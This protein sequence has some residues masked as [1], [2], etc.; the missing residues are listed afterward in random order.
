MYLPTVSVRRHSCQRA[1]PPNQA[2]KSL[3][4]LARAVIKFNGKSGDTVVDAEEDALSYPLETPRRRQPKTPPRSAYDLDITAILPQ[5]FCM[6]QPWAHQTN[7]DSRKNNIDEVVA[8]PRQVRE[9][10]PHFQ[11]IRNQYDYWKL[12]YQVLDSLVAT[13][14]T[15]APTPHSRSCSVSA[16]RFNSGCLCTHRA[17]RAPLQNGISRTR[18]SRRSYSMHANVRP[19]P[20]RSCS[21][22]VSARRQS[23]SLSTFPSSFRVHG[24]LGAFSKIVA[25]TSRGGGR[26]SEA[27][28][29]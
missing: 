25:S 29:A 5:L 12:K 20:R 15:S 14:P 3:F 7:K 6:G 9:P 19:I 28:F 22:T 17:L 1:V 24:M 13:A 26:A 8:F 4:G 21:S 23:I 27:G 11:P 2:V 10:L 18:S 16:T